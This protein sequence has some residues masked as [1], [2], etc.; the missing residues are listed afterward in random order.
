VYQVTANGQ[1]AGITVSGW[2]T[3]TQ[4]PT[5]SGGT[6]DVIA[7]RYDAAGNLEQVELP[8]GV[9]SDYGYDALNRLTS[10]VVRHAD[11]DKLLEQTFMLHANGQRDYV[12]EKRYDGTGGTPTSKVKID[13]TYDAL[14]RLVTETRAGDGDAGC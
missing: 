13:W 2:D 8:S 6:P 3:A 5:F 10:L 9:R 4:E 11:D 7:Y 1:S 12:I 14:N